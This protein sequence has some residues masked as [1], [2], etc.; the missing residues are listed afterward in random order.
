MTIR[1]HISQNIPRRFLIKVF[2]FLAVVLLGFLI[3]SNTFYSSFHLDDGKSIVDNFAIRDALNFGNIW[4]FSKTRFITYLSFAINYEIGGLN[5]FGY[6]V[7]NFSVH[8]L[9]CLILYLWVLAIFKTPKMTGCLSN[10]KPVAL[11]AALI[12][13]AHPIQTQAVTYIVQRTASLAALFYLSTLFFYVRA[14]TDRNL[15]LYLISLGFCFT[16]MFIK[17]NTFTLPFTI[18][19]FEII[20]FGIKKDEIKKRVFYLAPFFSAMF[21]VPLIYFGSG[22]FLTGEEL[23]FLPTETNTISPATYLLTEFNVLLTYLRLCFIPIKQNLDYDY[24]LSYSLLEP[25]TLISF[26]F[27]V[28][29]FLVSLKIFKRHRLISFTIFWFFITLSVESSIIPIRDVIFEHRLYLP[30][31]GISIFLACVLFNLLKDIKKFWI[32]GLLVVLVFSF[33]TYKRNNVWKTQLDL[34]TDVSEKSPNKARVYYGLG[35]A[36]REIEDYDR[37]IENYEKAIE[38]GHKTARSYSNLGVVYDIK[39]KHE[40]AEQYFLESIKIDS[41][42]VRPFMNL[43]V[44]Y[45]KAGNYEEAIAYSQKAIEIDPNYAPTYYNLGGIYSRVGDYENAVKFSLKA[46]KIDPYLI[47]AYRNL[48]GF[49][50]ALGQNDVAIETYLRIIQISPEPDDHYRLAVEYLRKGN[51]ELAREQA[52]ELKSLGYDDIHEKI[53]QFIEKK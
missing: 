31:A 32:V 30:M 17:E 23:G 21:V 13:L 8:L 35:R 22:N 19:I 52:L 1:K 43:A 12:F 10:G 6:H 16:A 50:G 45:A 40:K 36:Y 49:Y 9:T 15:L 39:G 24:Q 11:L 38:M 14:R 34:W 2:I 25:R 37:A 18:F 46:I 44:I 29:L 42:Y 28:G 41:N 4:G 20:F 7:F 48:A 5:V 47:K 53:I 51:T 3:Y 27:L 33:L 26:L